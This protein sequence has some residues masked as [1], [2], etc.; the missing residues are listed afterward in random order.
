[1]TITVTFGTSDIPEH[2]SLLQTFIQQRLSSALAKNV[3]EDL[4][5]ICNSP[6]N[7][8]FQIYKNPS[9]FSLNKKAVRLDDTE[10][11]SIA[12]Y[13]SAEDLLFKQATYSEISHCIYF[14]PQKSKK[15]LLENE[16][17]EMGKETSFINECYKIML[18]DAIKDK[19]Y[20]RCALILLEA[21]HNKIL[22]EMSAPLP[23]QILNEL[24]R[25]IP[26]NSTAEYY[27]DHENN[28]EKEKIVKFYKD[29]SKAQRQ[30][31][32]PGKLEGTTSQYTNVTSN[33]STSSVAPASLPQ[34]K[35]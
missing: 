34:H 28:L 7:S 23:S 24:D 31:S 32:A 9:F 16:M 15:L 19:S 14:R 4:L 22:F 1:M 6:P 21:G 27:N 25:T 2:P 29:D 35:K 18:T 13:I 33:A 17:K 30:Q 26:S 11:K 12:S 10:M 8:I 3:S 20:P 5:V